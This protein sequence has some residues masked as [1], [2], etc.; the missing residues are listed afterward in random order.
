MIV[1]ITLVLVLGIVIIIIA[2]S[3]T[4]VLYYWSCFIE[5]II[6]NSIHST[7]F[8]NDNSYSFH[9]LHFSLFLFLFD[10]IYIRFDYIKFD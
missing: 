3:V 4:L 7:L 5:M 9:T 6:Q 10:I 2:V 8:K 1:N